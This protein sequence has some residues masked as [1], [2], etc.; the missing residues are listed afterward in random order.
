MDPA[1]AKLIGAGIACIG[2]GGAGVGVGIDVSLSI[3]GSETYFTTAKDVTFADFNG[4]GRIASGGVGLIRTFGVVILGTPPA[5]IE[6]SGWSWG[7]DLSISETV[8][9]WICLPF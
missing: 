3:S 8:G 5:Y 6:T 1:A 4:P 9:R 7:I 2:M